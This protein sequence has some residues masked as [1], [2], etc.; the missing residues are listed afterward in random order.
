MNRR[1]I[2]LSLVLS[3]FCAAEA[4][5][6]AVEID[7]KAVG[8]IVVGKYPKMNACFTPA[9]NLA[10]ARVYF[11]PEGTPS[12]Y[13]VDMKSD[14]PCF[15]GVLPRPGKKLVGKKIEYYVEGQDKSFNAGRTA[16]FAPIVVNNAQECK[17]EAPAAP[18]LNNATV[19]VFPALPAGFVGGGIGTAAVVGIAAAGAAAAGTAAVVASNNNDTTTTTVAIGGGNTT[20]TIV[21]ATT[22]TTTTTTPRATNRA[23]FAVLSTTP[24]P[25]SGQ[26]PLT[27]TFDLCKST[28]ADGDS[29]SFSYDFGDGSTASGSCV[30]SHTYQATFRAASGGVRAQD[31]TYTATARVSDPG[32]LSAERSRNVEV[33]APPANCATPTVVL[34]PPPDGACSSVFVR[35]RTTDTD[36]VSLCSQPANF[37]NCNTINARAARGEGS[38]TSKALSEARTCVNGGRS[39]NNFSADVPLNEGF[40]CYRITADASNN[41]GNTDT[42]PPRF[43]FNFCGSD[44][45]ATGK[46]D[47]DDRTAVWS[48]DLAVDGGRL[49]IVVN[50]GSPAFPARGRG[51]GS[52]RLAE[53]ENRV[54][55]VLVESAGKPGLWRIDLKPTEA[56]VAGSLRVITGEVVLL[57]PSAATFRLSGA[58]G[59]RIVFTFLKR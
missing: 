20:T 11:R 24:N 31:A 56:I 9:A 27:V 35:A 43:V 46:G 12:W 29:L 6:Q 3:V 37:S 33:G 16:E 42:A 13:Y 1:A 17:K 38:I 14:Q 5:P 4:R 58:Q 40:G 36:T 47:G 44:F 41:C 10:R 7:H 25:P 51:F 57:G 28:D 34:S 23:P 50:G 8:C 30:E 15:M 45:N 55:A 2:A 53:G 49:Q 19:A 22:T 39:G 32:G 48:S 52:A 59:E 26:S 21:A 54:E 18:F